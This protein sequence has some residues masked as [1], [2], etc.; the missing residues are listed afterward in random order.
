MQGILLLTDIQENYGYDYLT[1]PCPQHKQA[2]KEKKKPF[3]PDLN[4]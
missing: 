3:K 2:L 1:A 4:Q